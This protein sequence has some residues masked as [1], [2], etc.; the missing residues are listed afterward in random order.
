M[1]GVEDA[2]LVQS[3]F[4]ASTIMSPYQ[5]DCDG[6]YD[7][8]ASNEEY[9]LGYRHGFADTNNKEVLGVTY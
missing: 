8:K 2:K 7:P 4:C 6:I 9:C 5:V 3:S 1:K